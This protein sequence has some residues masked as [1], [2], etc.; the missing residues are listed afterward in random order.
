MVIGSCIDS[1]YLE[2]N[3]FLWGANEFGYLNAEEF[4]LLAT[5]LLLAVVYATVLVCYLIVLILQK[6]FVNSLH[7]LFF[8]TLI[9]NTLH[10]Y[11]SYKVLMWK[12]EEIEGI[13]E[14]LS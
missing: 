7:Y 4:P 13:I 14:Y 1:Q 9:F 6:S 11:L 12:N 2:V 5:S 10:F 3:P 8:V